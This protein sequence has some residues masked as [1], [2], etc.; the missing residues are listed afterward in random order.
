MWIFKV[1]ADVEP[2]LKKKIVYHKV[3]FLSFPI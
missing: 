2:G 3:V 1:M